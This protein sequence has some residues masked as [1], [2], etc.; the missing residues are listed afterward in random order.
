MCY[1]IPIFSDYIALNFSHIHRKNRAETFKCINFQFFLVLRPSFWKWLRIVLLSNRLGTRKIQN[2]GQIKIIQ[3]I[4]DIFVDI[5]QFT[6]SLPWFY[7]WSWSAEVFPF[8]FQ[9]IQCITKHNLCAPS[10]T[11]C[12]AKPDSLLHRSEPNWIFI[13]FCAVL[14]LYVTY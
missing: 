11:D 7:L 3:K 4:M 13:K 8:L 10:E 12:L 9:S 6:V 5:F 1:T 2:S 14:L